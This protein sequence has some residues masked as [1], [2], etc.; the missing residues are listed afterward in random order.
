MLDQVTDSDRQ[1]GSDEGR[2]IIEAAAALRPVIRGYQEEIERE[3]R[4]P[5]PLVEQLHAAGLYRMVVPR[6]L[7]GAQV[8]Q[9]TLLRAIELV[10]EGDGSVGWNIATNAQGVLATLGFPD[11]AVHE[12]FG[13]GRN[14][15]L[16]GTIGPRGGRAV[17]V[18][19][20]CLVSGQWP[21]GS[22]CQE[23]D[24][25]IASFEI[26]D[27]DQPRRNAD[28]RPALWRGLFRSTECAVIYTW[29]V[30]GLRGS[31]SHDWSLTNAFVPEKRM[32]PYPGQPTANQW[33]RW[34]GPLYALPGPAFNG[35]T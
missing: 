6:E 24:W 18:D 34:S 8:D 1:M 4:I 31:G 7:G 16:A 17:P 20:G 3:R 26:F 15:A 21:F 29:D 30:T 13:S 22:G 35:R 19:G 11:D 28:G 23:S 33:S 5:R 2:A 27:G 10:S 32:V 12:V 14:V 9:L 25:M